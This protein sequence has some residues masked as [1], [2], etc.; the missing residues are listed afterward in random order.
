M[1]YSNSHVFVRLEA[2]GVLCDLL[3]NLGLVQGLDCHL[4]I[5]NKDS[6][7]DHSFI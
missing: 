6:C 1:A 4:I 3:D 2:V 5:F 7:Y